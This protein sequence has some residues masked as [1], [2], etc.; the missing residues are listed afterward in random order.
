M[1]IL[2]EILKNYFVAFFFLF[3]AQSR[4]SIDMNDDLHLAALTTINPVFIKGHAL[5]R[6]A[7]SPLEPLSILRFSSCIF[8]VF[9]HQVPSFYH[10]VQI[11]RLKTLPFFVER[12]NFSLTQMKM[13]KPCCGQIFCS[14]LA[15]PFSHSQ[16]T[17]IYPLGPPQSIPMHTASTYQNQL[18]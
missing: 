10:Y 17:V 9:L 5:S 3:L 8:Y 16:V 13:G 11:F 2:N 4:G 6:R 1:Q 12:K 15:M 7:S 18:Y 14:N